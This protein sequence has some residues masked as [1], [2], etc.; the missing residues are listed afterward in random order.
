MNHLNHLDTLDIVCIAFGIAD[1][2][3]VI[4]YSRSRP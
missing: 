2:I 3:F 1:I 4:W